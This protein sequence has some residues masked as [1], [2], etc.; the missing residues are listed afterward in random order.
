MDFDDPMSELVKLKQTRGVSELHK[1]FDR[2]MTRLNLEPS[3]AISIFLEGLKPE[4]GD[5]IRILKPYYL[6]QAY[7]LARLQE[8]IFIK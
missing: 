8:T 2:A 3:Y 6:P 4:L 5:V 1:S 7:H